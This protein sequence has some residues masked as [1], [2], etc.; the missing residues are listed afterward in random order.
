MISICKC[1]RK[2]VFSASDFVKCHKC[3][4]TVHN[5]T[6]KDPIQHS[7]WGLLHSYSPTNSSKWNAA[8]A[9]QWYQDEWKPLI[10]GCGECRQHWAELEAKFPPDFSSPQAFFRWAWARHDDV[11]RIHSLRRRITLEQA[12][13]LF[14]P[15]TSDRSAVAADS[16]SI[17]SWK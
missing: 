10:P 7:A 11:S 9:R 5:G 16:S 8:T 6:G 17:D 13:L 12:Y 4:T 14:W 15:G 1:G 2:F 3:K